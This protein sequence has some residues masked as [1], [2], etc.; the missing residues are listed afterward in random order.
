MVEKKEI[1]IAFHPKSRLQKDDCI[2]RF[3]EYDCPNPSTLQADVVEGLS[4]AWSVSIRCCTDDRCKE[5][6]VDIAKHSTA[7]ILNIKVEDITIVQ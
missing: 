2:N 6:A 3:L 4:G 5:R 7:G 1:K